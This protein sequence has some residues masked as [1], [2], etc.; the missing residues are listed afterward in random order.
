M[1]DDKN[2]IKQVAYNGGFNTQSGRYQVVTTG[3]GDC[4]RTGKPFSVYN[5][6]PRSTLLFILPGVGKSSTS[7][8]GWD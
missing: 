4:L 5:Q 7:L 3:M 6:P 1:R 2:V 8:S